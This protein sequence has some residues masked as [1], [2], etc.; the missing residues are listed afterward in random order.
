VVKN[1]LRGRNYSVQKHLPHA[2]KATRLGGAFV[3][4]PRTNVQPIGAAASHTGKG[5][6]A[7]PNVAR[8]PPRVRPSRWYSDVFAGVVQW[9]APLWASI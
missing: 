4:L 8:H 6:V 7:I 2:K 3:V 9:R 5:M 1:L